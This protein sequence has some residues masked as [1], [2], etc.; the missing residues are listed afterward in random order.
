LR[1]YP[2][3]LVCPK[4]LLWLTNRTAFENNTQAGIVFAC[5]LIFINFFQKYDKESPDLRQTML[6]NEK[7]YIFLTAFGASRPA[8]TA[9]KSG[10]PH[11]TGRLYDNIRL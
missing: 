2:R 5:F 4:A 7:N 9:R 1:A 11:G 10:D 6:Y 8:G 3:L